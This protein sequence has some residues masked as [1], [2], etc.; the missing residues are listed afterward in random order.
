MIIP[1]SVSIAWGNLKS[2]ISVKPEPVEVGKWEY[3][4]SDISPTNH[5]FEN[6]WNRSTICTDIVTLYMNMQPENLPSIGKSFSSDMSFRC[7]KR[8]FVS[9]T[10]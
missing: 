2:R 1:N 4:D 6:Y 5:H 10:T 8:T 7:D 9:K 3:C